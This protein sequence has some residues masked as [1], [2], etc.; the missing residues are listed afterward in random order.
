MSDASI[1]KTSFAAGEISPLVWGR[2]DLNKFH[3]GCSVMR[4]AFVNYRGG[5]SSRAGTAWVGRCKQ[6]GSGYPPRNI[7]FRFS[8]TQ[9]YVLEFGDQYMR[10]VSNGS[11]VTET[12]LTITGVGLTYPLTIVVPGAPWAAG[13]WIYVQGVN[14]TSQIDNRTFIISA[15]AGSTFTLHDIFDRPVNG[16][17]YS[18][19]I[20]GGTAARLYTVAAPYAAVDLPFLKYTQS[21][22][23]MTL[24]CVNQ[25]TGTEY[26]PY[27]LQRS[28]VTSWAFVQTTYAS[29]ISPPTGATAATTTAGTWH[30][31][32]V[33]TSVDSN[34]GDESIASSI[35]AVDS[36]NIATTAGTITITW[37][38]VVGAGSYNVYC[39]PISEAATV[40]LGGLFQYVGMSFGAQFADANITP[41]PTKTPPLHLNPFARGAIEQANPVAGGSGYVQATTSVVLHTSTG[42]GAVIIPIVVGGAV[43]AY[44]IEDAGHDYAPGDTMTVA[45]A[46]TSA[47]AALVIGPQK[48]TYP[49]VPA[50][51]QQRRMYAYTTN[52]PDTYF[53]SQVGSYT[54]MDQSDIPIDSDAIVGTP[55]AQQVNG[56]QWLIPMPGGL[57]VG[58]GDDVWQLAGAGGGALTPSSEQATPQETYGF[59]KTLPPLKIGYNI[60]YVQP[61]GSA[62]REL[63]YNFYANIYA[64]QDIGFLSNHL[65]DGHTLLQ[66]AWARE[67]NKIVWAVRDDGK[68]LSLTYLKEQE[69]NGWSRHDTNGLVQSVCC[70]P[71]PPVDAP[72]FIVK[73]Y[74]PAVDQWFYYQERMD[75]RIWQTTEDVWAVDA[76][77]ALDQPTRNATITI[78]SATGTRAIKSGHV[79]S[80]GS[81]YTS[82]TVNVI[83]PTGQG[84]GAVVELTLA[85]GV[86]DSVVIVDPGKN[87]GAYV[88]RI[89][90]VTGR[91]GAIALVIDSSVVIGADNAV[92]VAGDVGSVVRV[93][94]GQAVVTAYVSPQYVNATLTQAIVDTVPNDPNGMPLPA[95]PGAWTITKPIVTLTNLE[96]LEGLMVSILADGS[97]AP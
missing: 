88:T 30:Y 7:P 33:V 50:Y 25:D 12:P 21:A 3:A 45:G 36:I 51:F 66:W 27:D 87:Y 92:F 46:G 48:G 75:N 5:S 28:G 54:N 97:V 32:Y 47:T 8:A 38:P 82:P 14:G 81:N 22:D 95:G 94:G 56:I 35:A 2:V 93:D 72:Y 37:N 40:P 61:Y 26:P 74:I 57:I 90:D 15:V 39:A 43:V 63:Q 17:A 78:S 83:D 76:G 10:V 67:P 23:V 52:K 34:T 24:C 31:Q 1:L 68:F 79:V 55:W 84:S 96:H 69:I 4:N 85:G 41:S 9:S 60:V 86:L 64:G 65:F 18:P 58:T 44:I 70:V 71:E 59:S 77:L 29:S 19:Y 13:D 53:A 42:S 89:Q 49:G 6:S 73:R 16:L 11:Y 20:S 80:G 91:G 62:V